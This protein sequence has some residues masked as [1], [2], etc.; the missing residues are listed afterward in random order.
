LTKK[1]ENDLII[2]REFLK[3]T[4]EVAIERAYNLALQRKRTASSTR[5]FGPV[6]NCFEGEFS[7]IRSLTNEFSDAGPWRAFAAKTFWAASLHPWALQP[8]RW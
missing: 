3:V 4:K 2:V 6:A 7:S 8:H 5:Q 1:C